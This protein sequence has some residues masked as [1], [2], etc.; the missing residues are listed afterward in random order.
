[1]SA[2]QV[3][4]RTIQRR[5][6]FEAGNSFVVRDNTMARFDIG[7]IHESFHGEKRLFAL[8]TIIEECNKEDPMVMLP[9]V[10]VRTSS[11]MMVGLPAIGSKAL[12]IVDID[13]KQRYMLAP[14]A[15]GPLRMHNASDNLE[16]P[17]PSASDLL[18][19]IY[20]W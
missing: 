14:F 17:A 10:R 18:T 7:F 2:N 5:V 4:N 16:H 6:S 9:L 3:E 11:Q 19:S 12:Y 1:M 15:K 20:C 8:M 13:P